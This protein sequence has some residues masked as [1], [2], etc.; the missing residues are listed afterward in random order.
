M[1][2]EAKGRVAPNKVDIRIEGGWR[3]F[4]QEEADRRQA[5]D[6]ARSDEWGR[7]LSAN[8]HLVGLIAECAFAKYTGLRVDFSKNYDCGFDFVWNGL[9]IDVKSTR[10]CEMPLVKEL[11]GKKCHRFVMATVYP[12]VV[13]LL[14]WISWED[15]KSKPLVEARKGNHMNHQVEPQD[16]SPMAE[17]RR[18]KAGANLLRYPGGKSKLLRQL[19]KVMPLG[20]GLFSPERYV[21]P[22][23]GGGSVAIRNLTRTQ[24]DSVLLADKDFSLI[25]LWK[26]VRDSPLLLVSQVSKWKPNTEDW[27]K[28]KELDGIAGDPVKVAMNKL[29]LQYCSH[30]GIGY[31]AGGPQGGKNQD[32]EYK[33]G[34]RWNTDRIIRTIQAFSKLLKGVDIIHCDFEQIELR[35]R[36]FVFAD[37][38]Y[39]VA[40]ESLYR[41]SF[42]TQDHIR[43]RDWITCGDQ[44]WVVT[45]DDCNL[46][47]D[48]YAG[49]TITEVVNATGNNN[50]KVELLIAKDDSKRF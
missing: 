46:I 44:D 34:C 12:D 39:A 35:C 23:I 5:R 37:P 14:G 33:I 8:P 42:S 3:V 48:L 27:Y 13:S 41:H 43:L 11:K 31:L 15:V 30:A 19:E 32:S 49:H 22:F 21:E 24:F 50:S 7:G 17:M 18:S 20:G 25:E 29:I 36:D 28:A 4:C 40:G 38:P 9:K 47:R 26:C 6:N 45:Y 16:L 1:L 2:V 10:S